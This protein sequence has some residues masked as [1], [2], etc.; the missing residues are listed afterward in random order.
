VGVA[1]VENSI[2]PMSF[3]MNGESDMNNVVP[4]NG[5]NSDQSP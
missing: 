3:Y 2:C 5:G 1:V 4:H